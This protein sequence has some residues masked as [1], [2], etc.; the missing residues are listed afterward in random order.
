MTALIIGG[1]LLFVDGNTLINEVSRIP[2]VV[3]F[4]GLGLGVAQV[5]LSAWRWRYTANLLGLP[6]PYMRAVREYYLA[7]FTNQVLP[8][9]VLGDVN[10]ALRHGVDSRSRIAA[11]HAVAIERLSGQ[12][13]LVAVAVS[14]LA[15]LVQTGRIVGGEPAGADSLSHVYWLLAGLTAVILPG[16]FL[17]CRSEMVSSYFGRLRGDLAKALLSWPALPVQLLTSLLVIASYLAV[18]LVLASGAEYIVDLSSVMVIATLCSLLLLS[19]V[20]PLT[21]SGWGVREGVAVI[22]WPMMGQPSEQGVALSVAYGA[23]I[24]ISSLPGILFLFSSPVRGR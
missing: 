18:F 14:G 9:G 4:A 13:V 20:I 5:F 2:P 8:G 15:W 24:F 10:R 7:T 21:V 12:V 23:M 3:I 16:C 19:M 11:A 1:V 22:L 17:V 6:M